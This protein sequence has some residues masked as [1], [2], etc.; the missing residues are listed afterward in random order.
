MNSGQGAA[1]VHVVVPEGIDDPARPSGGNVYDRRVCGGLAARGWDVHE[2]H[3]TAETL[4]ATITDLPDHALVVVDGLIA[5]RAAAVLVPAARRLHLVVLMHM[6]LDG[7][8]EC[9]VLSAADAVLTT[10][11]WTRARLLDR[12]LLDS[13][14]V[15]AAPPGADAAGV[16]PGSAAGGELLCVAAV[17]AHKGHDTLLTALAAL[18]DLPWRLT[19]VGALDRDPRFVRRMRERGAAAGLAGR[20]ILRGPLVGAELDAAYAAADVL[21]LPSRGETFGMVI[22]EALA[23][24]LPVIT[25]AVGGA[26]EAL[27]RAGSARPG[28]LVPADDPSAL[29][30][31]LRRWLT[32]EDLRREL[33]HAAL[34]RRRTLT[35]WSATADCIAGV[36]R[37]VAAA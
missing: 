22:T 26:P 17:G 15:V 9:A 7:A 18:T 36:L 12:Y 33:R 27:G 31:E 14:R 16:V 10:S 19:S 35:R 20:V 32:D 3:V 34:A 11:A 6:P 4:A 37:H 21:V 23:R 2:H 1:P 30:A 5:S 8:E 28:L 29:S 13:M 25:T 24:G